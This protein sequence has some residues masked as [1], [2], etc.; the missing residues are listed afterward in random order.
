VIGL[1]VAVVYQARSDTEPAPPAAP[2]ET[3]ETVPRPEPTLLGEF[4]EL[5]VG[6]YRVDADG[7]Q[8]T[9]LSATF[10]AGGDR[11][12]GFDGGV[13]RNKTGT[14]DYTVGLIIAEVS[15]VNAGG[16]GAEWIDVSGAAEIASALANMQEVAVHEQVAVV[17]T[18]AFGY[19]AYHLTIGIPSCARGQYLAW[20]GPN[21]DE[22]SYN[23]G[24]SPNAVLE[25]WVLDVNG[26]AV[27]IEASWHDN[28][29]VVDRVALW[30]VIGSLEITP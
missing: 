13:G 1:L 14:D 16:C 15:Q 30:A 3:L 4:E 9:T 17:P 12:F 10:T 6:V 5:P 21:W 20:R 7:H 2:I 26:V 19:P 11:W 22:R 23:A 8:A 18:T 27:L 29:D 24:G 25:Y 28:S